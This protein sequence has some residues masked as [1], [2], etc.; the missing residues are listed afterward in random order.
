MVADGGGPA[1]HHARTQRS[2][3]GNAGLAGEDAVRARFHVMGDLDQIVDLGASA[4]DGGAE[5]GTID[6][7]AGPELDVILN[8]DGADLGYLDVLLAVPAIAEAVS[9]KHAASVDNNAVADGDALAND[10]VGVKLAV[11]TDGHIVADDH[12]G[13]EGAA[14]PQRPPVPMPTP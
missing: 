2:R 10:H 13:V 1:E 14:R 4:D 11:V 5:F 7:D 9:A 3:T 12:A 8:D 6:A